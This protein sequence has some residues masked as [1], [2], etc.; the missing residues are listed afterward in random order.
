MGSSGEHDQ[1]VR[2]APPQSRACMACLS[3]VLEVLAPLGWVTNGGWSVAHPQ[4]ATPKTL[5]TRVGLYVAFLYAKQPLRI[6]QV[7]SYDVPYSFHLND[8]ECTS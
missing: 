1:C 3:A 7:P 6:K 2:L 4:V 8:R 5:A